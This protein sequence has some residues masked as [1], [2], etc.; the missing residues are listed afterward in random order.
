MIVSY[1]GFMEGLNVFVFCNMQLF[2]MSWMYQDIP[3]LLH[4]V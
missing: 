2:I 3:F 1:Y 4:G